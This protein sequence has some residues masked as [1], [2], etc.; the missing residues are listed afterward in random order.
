[1]LVLLHQQVA[2]RLPFNV[3]E[4]NIK[5]SFVRKKTQDVQCDIMEKLKRKLKGF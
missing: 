3:V 2:N 4:Q 5:L 1:M